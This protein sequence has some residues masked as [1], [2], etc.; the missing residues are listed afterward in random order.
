MPALGQIV[1][2]KLSAQDADMINRRRDDFRAF[3]RSQPP[4]HQPG[5]PG[6]TG[7]VA[8]VGNPVQEGDLY[9]AVVARLFDG[10]DGANLQV[11]LDGNDAFWAT[12]RREGDAPG[13]WSYPVVS[14]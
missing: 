11:L 12:S 9:P 3:Q 7:H 1:L 6:A 13:Q 8:H 14:A 4:P 5:Q 2:Y 10:Y